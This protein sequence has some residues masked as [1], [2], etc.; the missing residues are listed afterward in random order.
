MTAT[1]PALHHPSAHAEATDHL[2]ATTKAVAV[3]HPQSEVTALV[4]TITVAAHLFPAKTTTRLVTVVIAP[5]PHVVHRAQKTLIHQ[6]VAAMAEK[7]IPMAAPQ[8]EAMK[9]CM[10]LT[11]TIVDRGGL[12][13]RRGAMLVIMRG[14]PRDTGESILPP[15]SYTFLCPSFISAWA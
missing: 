4:V 14:L 15:S 8:D 6:R 13:R 2:E 1:A 9:I 12:H 3:A 10:Q 11:V 5:R 7:L